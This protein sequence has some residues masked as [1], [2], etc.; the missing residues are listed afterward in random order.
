MGNN[1]NTVFL[2][3]TAGASWPIYDIAAATEEPS[4]TVA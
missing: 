1:P 2:V 3:G 4:Q